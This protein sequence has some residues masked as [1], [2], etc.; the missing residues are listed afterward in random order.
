MFDIYVPSCAEYKMYFIKEDRSYIIIGALIQ[1]LSWG[2][3]LKDIYEEIEEF[4]NAQI[5][6]EVAKEPAQW[7]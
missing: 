7:Q 3:L 2:K 1:T 5:F 6:S 4:V